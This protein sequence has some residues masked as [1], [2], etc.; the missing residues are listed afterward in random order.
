MLGGHAVTMGASAPAGQVSIETP[1]GKVSVDTT[2][3]E[4]WAKRM[5]AAGKKLERA[6]QSGDQAAME[7]AIKEMSALQG[8][9]PFNR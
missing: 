4:A 3:M 1:Q 5:E 2:K 7:E 8:E 9:Q 6:Q